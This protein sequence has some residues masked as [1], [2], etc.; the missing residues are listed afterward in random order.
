[1]NLHLKSDSV[2]I[3]QTCK[4]D[5]PHTIRKAHNTEP[6]QKKFMDT[7]TLQNG[8]Q[9]PQQYHICI[10]SILICTLFLNYSIYLHYC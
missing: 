10:Q 9:D 1:M 5:Q 2:S 3:W 7:A 6:V 8:L 4:I